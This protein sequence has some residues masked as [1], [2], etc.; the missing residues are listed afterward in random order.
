MAMR[1][2]TVAVTWVVACTSMLAA[3]GVGDD[4]AQPPGDFAITVEFA[5]GSVPPPDHVQWT[6]TVDDD[7][8]GTLAYSPDYPGADVPTFRAQFDV[9][10]AA[11]T[12]LYEGLADNDLLGDQDQGDDAPIGGPSESATVTAD[13][14]A[15]A[16]PAYADGGVPLQPVERQIHQ[17]VP[18][19]VWNDFEK[20]R[21]AYAD[22]RYG[23]QP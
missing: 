13:G 11:M 19:Q 23:S 10:S 18:R 8:Q 4:L 21:E 6:L 3:C 17:L 12:G 22:R 2:R 20:R 15:F 14:D 1:F 16:I 5:D 9:E 7:G